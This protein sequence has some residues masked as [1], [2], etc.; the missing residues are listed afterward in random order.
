MK[1][2]FEP[3]SFRDPVIARLVEDFG[4]R[5]STLRAAK[6]ELPLLW[7]S[8][9]VEGSPLNGGGGSAWLTTDLSDESF[10]ARA[11]LDIRN[12]DEFLRAAHRKRA[13]HL[14]INVHAPFFAD[15]QSW[16]HEVELFLDDRVFDAR[17]FSKWYVQHQFFVPLAELEA[18]TR[19][20][21]QAR[22]TATGVLSDEFPKFS[23]S[24]YAGSKSEIFDRL[25]RGAIWLFSSAR[26]GSTWLAADI[27]CAKDRARPIDESGIGRMFAPLR[28]DP[29]RL[30]NLEQRAREYVESGFEFETGARIRQSAILP[31]FERGFSDLRLENQIL[32]RRT[33]R[34]FYRM[35]RETALEHVVA[36]WGARDFSRVV[37]KCPN[38]AHGA[39]HIMRA[40]PKS[41]MISLLRD[42][43]DVMRSRFSSFGSEELAETAH[44][45]LRLHAIAF[46]AHWWNFQ[47][48]IVAAAYDAHDPELRSFIRYEDLRAEPHRVLRELFARLNLEGTEAEIAEL[49]A[50]TR[51]ENYNDRGE[52]RPR[53]QGL[54]GGYRAHFSAEEIDLMNAIMGP[55]LAKY[56]YSLE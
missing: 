45:G 2:R 10:A 25:E 52:N 48:D 13:S 24:L 42:G 41:R 4:R 49:V 23:V 33:G 9:E 6:R 40:F 35:L 44:R 17:T 27:L 39:D 8:T 43:R 36:E 22:P 21:L 56:G 11:E 54:I 34:V 47:T 5:P 29:E 51:L 31:P 26:A 53:Q 15:H 20:K 28:W 12:L 14:L 19:L 50:D 7:E 32:S 55:N 16:E 38:D 1:R 18:T 30:Y 46:Y 3:S 37:F